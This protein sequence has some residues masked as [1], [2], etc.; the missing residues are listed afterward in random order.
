MDALEK[1]IIEKYGTEIISKEECSKILDKAARN[2]LIQRKDIKTVSPMNS[3]TLLENISELR[4]QFLTSDEFNMN[5]DDEIY[6]QL[7]ASNESS[8]ILDNVV[9][10]FLEYEKIRTKP[11]K[12]YF[13]YYFVFGCMCCFAGI[14]LY[15][16]VPY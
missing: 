4:R 16:P 13:G 11:K 8:K 12:S 10:A 7:S 1:E 6:E 3:S 14:M 15:R 5:M 9:K 2:G